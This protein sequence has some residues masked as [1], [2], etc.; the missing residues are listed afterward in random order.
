MEMVMVAR[1]ARDAGWSGLE[2][3]PFGGF[4]AGVNVGS[5]AAEVEAMGATAETV[6]M[7]HGS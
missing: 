2:R 5:G 1:W 7:G 4:R 3:T 6:R